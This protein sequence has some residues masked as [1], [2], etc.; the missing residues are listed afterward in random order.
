MHST[1]LRIIALIGAPFLLIDFYVNGS[2]VGGADYMHTSWSGVFGLI[3]MTGW[4]C[5]ILALIKRNAN[6][7]KRI[8]RT[9]GVVQLTLLT[10]AN[11]WNIYEIIS[12]GANTLLFNV[13]DL[14]WP[15]SNVFMLVLGIVVWRTSA[16][17]GWSKFAP[18]ASGLWLPV[19]AL[20]N[21]LVGDPELVMMIAGTYSWLAWSWLGLSTTS[22]VRRFKVEESAL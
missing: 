13:L 6:T 7:K 3:Y 8:I 12:P 20:L 1:L 14:F 16:L 21:L 10:F 4:S 9:L 19:S 11:F 22:N 2:A 18:F 15:L 17:E 5:S